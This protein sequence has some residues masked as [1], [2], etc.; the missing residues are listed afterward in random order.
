MRRSATRT[1]ASKARKPL[2]FRRDAKFERVLK[3]AS[4]H[5]QSRINEEDERQDAVLANSR[6]LRTIVR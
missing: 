3:D 1:T 5:L 6:I 2:V 4:R